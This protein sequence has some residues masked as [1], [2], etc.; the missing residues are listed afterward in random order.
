MDGDTVRRFDLIEARCWA[1]HYTAAAPDLARRLGVGVAWRGSAVMTAIGTEDILAMNRTIAL[2]VETPATPGDVDAV[3]AF[4]RDRGTARCFVQVHPNAAQHL[5]PLLTARGLRHHNN[6]AKLVY[7]LE[8]PVADAAT[9]LTI[10]EVGQ[11]DA[12]TVGQIIAT[13]FEH[14]PSLRPFLGGVPGR[15]GWH[16]Y[17]ACDG[18]RALGAAL[19]YVDPPYACLAFGATLHE[20]RGRGAQSALIARRLQ[21]ARALGCTLAMSETAED[22]PDRPSQS[23][24][25]LRRAGFDLA[26]LRA[27]YVGV[28]T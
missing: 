13:A 21:D 15:P 16:A 18:D 27:N 20:G 7:Q 12:A 4:Y 22:L 25:N 8:Q 1:E 2:G 3:L 5:V 17:L 24:H 14:P 10:R 19:L 28:V 9:D 11:D 23:Y 26:Y 6:W